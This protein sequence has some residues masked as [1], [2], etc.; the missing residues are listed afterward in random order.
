MST[1]LD[2][3]FNTNSVRSLATRCETDPSTILKKQKCGRSPNFKSSCVKLHNTE[4]HSQSDEPPSD[5]TADD[6]S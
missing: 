4:R 1:K 2:L 6:S 3:H 5:I